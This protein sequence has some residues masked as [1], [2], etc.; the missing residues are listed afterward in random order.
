MNKQE[1]IDYIKANTVLDCKEPK[2]T[3]DGSIIIPASNGN[4]DVQIVASGLELIAN[5]GE[6]RLK[7]LLN[8]RIKNAEKTAG[9]N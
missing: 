2:D 6:D 8:S 3:K 5:R 1:I 7:E 4:K 9:I